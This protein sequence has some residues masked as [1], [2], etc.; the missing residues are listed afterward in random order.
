MRTMHSS[1]ICCARTARHVRPMILAALRMHTCCS[2]VPRCIGL[3]TSNRPKSR[4]QSLA[5]RRDDLLE[6][7]NKSIQVFLATAELFPR[8]LVKQRPPYQKDPSIKEG[9][10]EKRPFTATE[11]V[12]HM[13]DVERLWQYR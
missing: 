13:A 2:W 6:A 12:Y 10:I 9:E 3:M 8:A 11:I 4:A 5:S 7:F 1:W